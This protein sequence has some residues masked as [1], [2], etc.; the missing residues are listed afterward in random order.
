MADWDNA[1][2]VDL[3]ELQRLRDENIAFL[4]AAGNNGIPQ[5]VAGGDP[6]GQEGMVRPAILN[7]DTTEEM[8]TISVRDN[9]SCR[10]PFPDPRFP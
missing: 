1:V 6:N 8:S 10:D 5:L 3:C 7:E 4:S 2:V 9:G